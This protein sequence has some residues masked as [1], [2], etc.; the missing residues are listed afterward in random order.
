MGEIAWNSLKKRA[1]DATK[2]PEPGWYVIECTKAEV[3]KASTTGNPM[4]AAQFKIVEGPAAGKSGIFNNFNITPDNDFAM[5]MFFRHMTALGLG[6]SFFDAD[7]SLD[8]VAETLVG[9]RVNAQL[10]IRTWKDQDRAQIENM[11]A[12]DGASTV[13]K[14]STTTGGIPS[15]NGG[16]TSNVPS[17]SGLTSGPPSGLPTVPDLPV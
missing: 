9:R 8:Q 1:E 6:S 17:P 7:P 15:P 10:G 14:P 2:P 4:I 11:R 13:S 5:S 12:L 16:S 3:K